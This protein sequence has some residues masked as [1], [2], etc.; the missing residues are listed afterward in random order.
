VKLRRLTRFERGRR[1]VQDL[2][3]DEHGKGFKA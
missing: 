2:D 1:E 3:T